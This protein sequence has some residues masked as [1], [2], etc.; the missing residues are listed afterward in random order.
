MKEPLFFATQSELRKWF[1]KHHQTETEVWIGY[2]KKATGI[3]SID[4]SQSVDEAICFGW[5]DGIRRKIDEQSY[6][7]RFTPRN[8]KSHWSAVN[9]AKVEKL[10]E[11]GL[12]MPAGL[13][14]YN[15]RDE[16][17]SRQASYE[18]QHIELDQQ[19]EA[20]IRQNE[21][22]WLYYKNLA[23]SYKKAS[24]HW[25]MSAKNEETRLRRLDILIQS[26]ETEKKIPLL[27]RKSE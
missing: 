18:R 23:A 17:K 14:V 27:R 13:E 25:V 12:I 2:Y 3:P 8:P 26:C 5:I 10:L 11:L 24:I 6:K 4:W 21:K 22:A 20:K 1:Q 19:Y 15:Q 9:L 7:I 16:K